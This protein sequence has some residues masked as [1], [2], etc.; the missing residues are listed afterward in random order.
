[1]DTCITTCAKRE[2][3]V[4]S[5]GSGSYPMEEH[6]LHAY[7]GKNGL[8][9]MVE[10]ISDISPCWIDEN[11]CTRMGRKRSAIVQSSIKYFAMCAIENSAPT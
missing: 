7:A 3:E 8:V 5:R 2:P 6:C 4:V 11:A 10:Y 1:M 9:Q